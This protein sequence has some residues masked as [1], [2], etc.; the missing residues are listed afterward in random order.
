MWSEG[1]GKGN[2]IGKKNKE[3]SPQISIQN[4]M[5]NRCWKSQD[6]ECGEVK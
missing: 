5:G 2:K 6:L 4:S 3:K 1:K